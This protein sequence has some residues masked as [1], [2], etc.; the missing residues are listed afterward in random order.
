MRFYNHN[1]SGRILNRFS[2][3]LGTIDE[4][5]PSVLVDVIEVNILFYQKILYDYNNF[6][7]FQ[8]ALLLLGVVILSSIVDPWLLLPSIVVMI[9]FYFLRLIYIETSRSVKRIESISR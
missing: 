1:P 8:I 7:L 6:I 4:Y 5:I 2:K 3:D 9:F